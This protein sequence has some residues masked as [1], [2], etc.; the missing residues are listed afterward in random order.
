MT[1]P[2]EVVDEIRLLGIIIRSDLKTVSN[3]ENLVNRANKRLWIVRV[4]LGAQQ[5][6]LLDVYTKQVR[7]V[8]ELAVPAWHGAITLVEQ[9]D[10]E[11]IQKCVAHIILGDKYVSYKQ[12]L[13][14]LNLESLQI[15]RGKL[16]LKFA[17][18]AEKHEKF[19]NWFKV[20]DPKPNTRQTI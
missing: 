14:T 4:S 10:I 8:L 2:L 19:K 11:R 3:T 9:Q 1:S 20:S 5:D 7:S 16:C 12:A 6:D 18:K 13:L 15:R 17:K